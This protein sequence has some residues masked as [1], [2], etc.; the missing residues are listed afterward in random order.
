VF[1]GDRCWTARPS[2]MAPPAATSRRGHADRQPPAPATNGATEPGARRSG[3]RCCLAGRPPPGGRPARTHPPAAGRMHVR[4]ALRLAASRRLPSPLSSGSEPGWGPAEVWYPGHMV[5]TPAGPPGAGRGQPVADLDSERGVQ[6]P[7]PVRIHRLANDLPGRTPAP[8]RRAI[9]RWSSLLH[10]SPGRS[11]AFAELVSMVSSAGRRIRWRRQRG[12]RRRPALAATTASPMP[13]A[14]WRRRWESDIEIDGDPELQ[15]VVRSMLFYC[16][17]APTLGTALGNPPMGLSSGGYYGAH[18]LG[19]R[20]LD[21]PVASAHHP[22]RRPPLV[23]FRART[24]APPRERARPTAPRRHVPGRRHELGA[25]DDALLRRANARS[26]IHVTGD[27]AQA[28]WQYFSP[29][30][31]PRGSPGRIPRYPR[32]RGFLGEPGARLDQDVYH[33]ENVVSVHEGLIGVTDDA[34]HHAVARKTLQIAAAASRRLGGATDPHWT[35]SPPAAP[36][37]RL[38]QRVLPHLRGRAGLDPAPS[39]RLLSYPLGV[40]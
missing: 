29:P 31:T 40:P 17:A 32:H 26:E 11:Y 1:D 8:R 25:R 3:G 28:Q 10:A 35:S 6:H 21:V 14:A 12:R 27:V 18:L 34:L 5:V 22:G 4:F 7:G 16:S 19:L 20:Y 30:A 33:I 24:L 13:L 38:R 23:A 39:H 37:V 36:A 2:R 9:R 15:R